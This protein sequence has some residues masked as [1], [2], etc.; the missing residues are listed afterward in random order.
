MNL[1]IWLAAGVVVGAVIM[2][3]TGEGWWLGIGAGVGAVMGTNTIKSN[4]DED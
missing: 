3:F 1:G 2:A 4:S